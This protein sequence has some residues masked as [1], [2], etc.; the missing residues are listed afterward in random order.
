MTT[1]AKP[2]VEPSLRNVYARENLQAL[3][4]HC[5]QHEGLVV[6]FNLHREYLPRRG[7]ETILLFSQKPCP[8]TQIVK[9]TPAEVG[10]TVRVVC[11]RSE[12]TRW[13]IYRLSA[14]KEGSER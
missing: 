11:S 2:I 7:C 14:M 4:N 9:V 10:Y 5:Y 13:L 1:T 3:L 8:E 12:L 6:R